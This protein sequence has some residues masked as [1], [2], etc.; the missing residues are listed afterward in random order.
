MFEFRAEKRNHKPWFEPKANEHWVVTDV[1]CVLLQRTTAKE[2]CRR[3]I[4]AELPAGFIEEHGAVVVENHLNMIK[5]LNGAPRVAP[6][7]LAVLL[8]S[9]VVDQVFRCIN[10]SVAVSAYELEALPLP[11]PEEA[12]EIERLMKRRATRETLECAVERCVRQRG[13][14]MPLLPILAV[15]DIHERLQRIY[16]EGT[17]KAQRSPDAILL[18]APRS[19][20]EMNDQS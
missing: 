18:P 9:G 11:P 20:N 10:G 16:P 5:P 14:V 4:A 8:N 12:K 7:A 2:Q 17:A 1:P 19:P 13:R 6:A 3:L 15:T